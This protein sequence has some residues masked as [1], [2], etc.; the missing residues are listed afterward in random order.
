[1][2]STNEASPALA[3]LQRP[4]PNSH[5]PLPPGSH[6]TNDVLSFA[7]ERLWFLWQLEPGPTPYKHPPFL[8]LSGSRDYDAYEKALSADTRGHEVLRAI[9]REE[10][11]EPRQL[12]QPW[13]YRPLI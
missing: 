2:S 3:N 13:Q 8:R 10:A 11:G 4:F 9:F 5:P 1:M 12:I 6:D 7:Q